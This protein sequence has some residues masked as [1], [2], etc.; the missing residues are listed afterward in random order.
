MMR[1]LLEEFP[2]GQAVYV[3]TTKGN[4]HVGTIVN[5]IEDV[6]SLLA[7]DG[8]TRINLNLTDVSGVRA[9]S[10]EPEEFLP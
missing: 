4:V 6:V 7:P 1:S 8:Q 2:S 5:L 10:D 3:F 9:H